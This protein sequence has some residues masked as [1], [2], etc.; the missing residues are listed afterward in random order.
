MS[1]ISRN[2]L[3][4]FDYCRLFDS[5][6]IA[7]NNCRTNDFIL[8]NEGKWMSFFLMHGLFLLADGRLI[9]YSYEF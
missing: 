4:L 6:P 1:I 3:N 5:L 2:D 7:L 9:L 8:L